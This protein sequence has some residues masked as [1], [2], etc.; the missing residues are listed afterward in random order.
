MFKA[1]EEN[2]MKVVRG[3][4]VHDR[5]FWQTEDNPRDTFHQ[6][7]YR[8][9][10]RISPFVLTGQGRNLHGIHLQ[11]SSPILKFM[12][13]EYFR[14]KITAYRERKRNNVLVARCLE[15]GYV[16]SEHLR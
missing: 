10:P 2:M 15:P 1:R 8:I 7:M 11:I 3:G 6:K 12:R 14:C 4:A 9:S 16:G 13:H 5:C